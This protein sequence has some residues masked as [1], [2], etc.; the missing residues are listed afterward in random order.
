MIAIA[1]TYPNKIW[2]YYRDLNTPAYGHIIK[3]ESS[4]FTDLYSFVA[5]DFWTMHF[6]ASENSNKI[7]YL[8]GV[9]TRKYD[10]LSNTL[11]DIASSA[12]P[13]NE[14][15][16]DVTDFLHVDIRDMM[17][18]SVSSQ[19]RVYVGH[20]GGV[21]WGEFLGTG[22][23]PAPMF[24]WHQISDD[25]T[26]GLQTNEFYGISISN[27]D[28]LVIQG[29]TQ[30]CSS[31]IYKEATDQWFHAYAG[32]GL[33]GAV[34]PNSNNLFITGGGCCFDANY[35][36]Y[37]LNTTQQRYLL[38]THGS[39]KSRCKLDPLNSSILYIG[40]EE[41]YQVTNCFAMTSTTSS[42]VATPVSSRISALEISHQNSLKKYIAETISK[43]GSNQNHMWRYNP[44][45]STWVDISTNLSQYSNSYVTDIVTKPSND[46]EVWICMGQTTNGTN[47]VFHSTD[48]GDHWS[49]LNLG[50]PSGIPALRLLY[51]YVSS[52]L[53]V[54]TDVG[55]FK[56]EEYRP[57]NGWTYLTDTKKLKIIT[58]IE[59]DYQ[60]HRL[61]LGTFGRGIWEGILPDDECY[62]S[63]PLTISTPVTWSTP[64]TICSDINI[65][66]GGQLNIASDISL[67]KAATVF[68]QSGGVLTVNGGYL[69]NGNI[70]VNNG[71]T[72]NIQGNGNIGLTNGDEIN[73]VQGAIINL[74][75][76]SVNID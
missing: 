72:L 17:I 55:L 2:F 68:I 45:T 52:C 51:D 11:V 28:D 74:N 65:V 60:N 6:G 59:R 33:E 19:D 61:I 58:D 67:S 16:A 1:N 18:L 40:A 23:C 35:Y 29:G 56:W 38:S 7:V 30:D 76:G 49:A 34:S 32:D 15:A 73:S 54:A 5:T 66:S 13:S 71:G 12:L 25:G 10:E 64:Q 42:I 46:D 8:G 27:S 26:D 36:V 22:A 41:L 3:Y 53:Y 37:D 62:D 21:A 39:I 20:D 43:T 69:H 4:V 75:Y 48:G 14:S 50:Y 57:E 63:N 31:F 70:E 9:A 44:S 47:K 24:C